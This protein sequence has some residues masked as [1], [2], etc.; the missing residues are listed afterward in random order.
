M[1]YRVILEVGPL[2]KMGIGDEEYTFEQLAR[3]IN[4]AALLDELFNTSLQAIYTMIIEDGEQ[5]YGDNPRIGWV[6]IKAYESDPR[7]VPIIY[8]RPHGET[9]KIGEINLKRG[10]Y[11]LD[12][13]G[14]EPLPIEETL[15]KDTKRVLETLGLKQ[16]ESEQSLS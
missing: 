6:R 10:T 11:T 1:S 8:T 15:Y 12:P 4:T 2:Q 7:E 13:L 16:K 5:K 9:I 3:I 14:D